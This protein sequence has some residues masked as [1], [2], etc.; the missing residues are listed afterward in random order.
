MLSIEKSV[1]ANV[2]ELRNIHDKVEL[3]MRALESAGVAAD[4]IGPLLIPIVLKKLPNV[5]RL[6]VS[7]KLG[8][9]NWNIN[10]FMA[11]IN[12]E[13]SARENFEFLKLVEGHEDPSENQ[14]Q[15]TVSALAV[16]CACFAE[17][18]LILV[19]SVI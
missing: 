8:T 14:E 11:S 12:E 3:N 15:R 17:T 9:D 10:D 1:T 2:K 6:Q 18:S 16:N 13:V 4:Q 5:V 19:I 7:R